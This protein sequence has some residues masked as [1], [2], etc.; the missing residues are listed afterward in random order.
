M[1]NFLSNP[2]FVKFINDLFRDSNSKKTS[3]S[4]ILAFI[5]FIMVLWFH[6]E[7]IKIM[8]EKKEID[9]ALLL[10]DF[11]FIS[12]IIMQKNYIN[13]KN[14]EGAETTPPI[15]PNEEQS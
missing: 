5:L 3:F 15:E 2:T 8:V 11:A 12:A 9:H 4:R 6:I 1:F 7:A 13:R 14:I 10:E